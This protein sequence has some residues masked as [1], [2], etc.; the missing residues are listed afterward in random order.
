MAATAE[1][2]REFWADKTTPLSRGNTPEFLCLVAGE[3]RLLFGEKAPVSVL[4]IGCGNGCLFDFL[5]FSSRFY[6]GVDFSPRM[7][8]VF[9]QSHPELDLVEADGSS[10]ADDRTYDVILV[11]DVIGHFTP[12]MLARHCRN[13][14]SMMHS[15]SLLVWACIPW[16]SLRHTYDLGLWSKS[17]V[18]SIVLWGKNKLRRA[19]GRDII[20]RWYT[21]T[22]VA[23]IA[24]ENSLSARFCGSISHPYR[25][26]TV[27][28]PQT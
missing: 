22:E 9:R 6:R 27:M 23:K 5:G 11:H 20:G 2:F 25:F 16:R 1:R 28:R 3:L 24:R 19:L 18:P 10:Y 4:E 12:D 21:T 14:R 15:D 26:H 17:G 13:A 8:E 7:L